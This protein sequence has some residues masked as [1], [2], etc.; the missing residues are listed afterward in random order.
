MKWFML[1]VKIQI[2]PGFKT[3]LKP[4]GIWGIQ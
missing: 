1:G 3:V 2:P 4:G